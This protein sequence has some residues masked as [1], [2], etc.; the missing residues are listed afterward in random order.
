MRRTIIPVILILF[1]SVA[2]WAATTTSVQTIQFRRGPES[3]LP[4]KAKMGEPLFTTDS[5]KLFMGYS[6]GRVEMGAVTSQD[7]TF[8][9]GTGVTLYADTVN[10][11][12]TIGSAKVSVP[13]TSSSAC[14]PGQWAVN[15]SYR[16]DCW[17]TNSWVRSPVSSW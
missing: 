2:V 17:S 3:M 6:T 9:A 11:A 10:N 16:F 14:T 5:H 15:S 12:L 13:N 4:T 1:A 8:K 7:L